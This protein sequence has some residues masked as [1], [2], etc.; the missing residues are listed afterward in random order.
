MLCCVVFASSG[1]TSPLL[2]EIFNA[3]VSQYGLNV[4]MPARGIEIKRWIEN[5]AQQAGKTYRRT[6]M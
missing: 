3:I 1:P 5:W 2:K 6:K 4:T